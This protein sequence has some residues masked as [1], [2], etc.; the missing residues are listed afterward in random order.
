[1][2][3]LEVGRPEEEAEQTIR[4][5]VELCEKLTVDYPMV[6]DYRSSLGHCLG[7]LGEFLRFSSRGSEAEP[8]LRRAAELNEKVAADSPSVALYQQ[9]LAMSIG[10]LGI[11]LRDTDRGEEAEPLMRRTLA[12]FERQ[13]HEAQSVPDSES[14][15]ADAHIELGTLLARVGRAAEAEQEYRRAIALFEKLAGETPWREDRQQD[16]ARTRQM[17]ANFLYRGG[18][19]VEAEHEY[20]QVI[21][22]MAKLVDGRYQI[23]L[24]WVLATVPL[25][26]LR[27]AQLAVRVAQEA[28]G[29][30]QGPDRQHYLNILG[31]AHYRAGDWNAAIEALEKSKQLSPAG[32]PS[33]WFFLAMACYQKGEKEKAHSWYD[34]G[35]EWMDR[36]FQWMDKTRAQDDELWRFRAEAAVLLGVT[37]HLTPTAKKEENA[38][39]RSKP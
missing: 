12:L 39:Q 18:R 35:V 8:Y 23:T 19:L 16:V 4:R 6:P 28:V 5:A 31:V 14:N 21:T 27:D 24:A 25:A 10:N 37:D 30:G 22:T 29:Q 3:I 1:M 20:R 7:Q 11:F 17:L 9:R 2:V 33:G 32:N 26:Q 34:K 13:A 15:Q 36:S 38:K